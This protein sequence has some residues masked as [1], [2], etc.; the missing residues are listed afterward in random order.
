MFERKTSN[1]SIFYGDYPTIWDQ[2]K[3]DAE[4]GEFMHSDHLTEICQ[5][6]LREYKVQEVYLL[7]V[8][9]CEHSNCRSVYDREPEFLDCLADISNIVLSR[10]YG[11]AEAENRDW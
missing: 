7:W 4:H 11:A 9:A 3:Y 6:Y 5:E 10:L 8:Y 1:I 2:M